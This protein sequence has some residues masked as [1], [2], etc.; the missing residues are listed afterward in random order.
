MKKIFILNLILLFIV[1]P[2]ASASEYLGKISTGPDN[3]STSSDNSAQVYTAQP[4]GSGENAGAVI[5]IHNQITDQKNN[6]SGKVLGIKYYGDNSLLRG[7]DNKIYI[8]EGKTKKYVSSLEELGKY[9]GQIIH[10]VSLE[11]LAGY[12]EKRYPDGALVRA[13]GDVKIYVIQAGKRRHI[14]NLE[15]L[16]AGFFGL[17]IFNVSEEEMSLYQVL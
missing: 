5:I 2:C 8:V 3:L 1:V 7:P 10:D 14:L 6:Q 4:A 12:K 15:E 17:E 16:R 13:R 9:R 11:E